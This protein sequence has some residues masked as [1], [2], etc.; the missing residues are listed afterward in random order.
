M[1][2]G[3]VFSFTSKYGGPSN[4]LKNKIKIAPVFDPSGQR[5]TDID[6]ALKSSQDWDAL[7]DTGATNSVITPQVISAFGLQ[8]VSKKRMATPH[9]TQEADCYY[10]NLGLPNGVA[11]HNLLVTGAIPVNCDILIGMDVIGSGDFAVS[12]YNGATSFSF[13]IPSIACIDF[14]NH[15]YL[16]PLVKAAQPGRNDPCSCG[17]GLKYKK[18]C[19]KGK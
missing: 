10:V 19:G 11:I 2:P 5:I 3:K 7:W 4:V 15:T 13:R 8:P 18:C 6:S 1:Q 14:V 16:V 17:S 12:N 9:G